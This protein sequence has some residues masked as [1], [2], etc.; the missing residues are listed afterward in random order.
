MEPVEIKSGPTDI[1]ATGIIISFSGNPIEIVF[2]PAIE[3]MRLILK[4]KDEE[5]NAKLR[6]AAEKSNHDTLILTFFNFNNPLGG[7]ST[8]P[9]AL[10]TLEGRKIYINYRIYHLE[11]CDKTFHYTIYMDDEVTSK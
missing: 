8:E 5:G 4:F 11:A 6:V 9:I 2:G 10:G 1:I 3:R 7:G